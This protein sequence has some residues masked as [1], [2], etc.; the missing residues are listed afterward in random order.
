MR[1]LCK[2]AVALTVVAL[3]ASP[4]FAQRGRGFNIAGFFA[5]PAAL[6]AMEDVQKELKLND[7]Q[8][9]KAA[10]VSQ[11]QQEAM[12]GLRG[13]PPEERQAKTAELQKASDKAIAGVLKPD[14]VKRLKQI[15]AQLA[16]PTSSPELEKELKITADQK[17]QI[18]AVAAEG[19]GGIRE[20]FGEIQSDPSGAAKKVT[21]LLKDVTDKSVKTLTPDQ[22]KKWKELTGESFKGNIT[23]RLPGA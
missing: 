20:L 22:Q 10:T 5:S 23:I 18:E 7:D 4:A 6:I 19:F 12:M 16:G 21:A 15:G 17:S 13:V 11:E 8:K 9:K 3:M 14:Q 2:M 1:K